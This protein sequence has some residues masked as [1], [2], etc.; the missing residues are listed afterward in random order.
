MK[1][2]WPTFAILALLFIFATASDCGSSSPREK[3]T[4]VPQIAGNCTPR[5]GV[6]V[7][8]RT[9]VPLV[10]GPPPVRCDFGAS[11]QG[12]FDITSWFWQR[13]DTRVTSTQEEF[14]SQFY[15]VP[16]QSR[17]DV[18]VESR[19]GGQGSD[20]ILMTITELG[21]DAAAVNKLILE[22][23]VVTSDDVKRELALIRSR[24]AQ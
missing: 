1:Q 8:A 21:S 11:V 5:T 17:V 3:G 18:T 9:P 14:T 10:V 23:D 4:P 13:S 20:V 6:S 19:G 15:E 24:R 22:G 7:E 12:E 2:T 16:G